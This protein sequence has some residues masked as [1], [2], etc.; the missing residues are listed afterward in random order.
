MALHRRAQGLS[1]RIPG[2]RANICRMSP[3]WAVVQQGKEVAD[4]AVVWLPG[5]G[6]E[7]FTESYVN[8]IP[9]MQGGTHVNGLRTGITE[10]VREFCEFRNL[11]PRGVKLAPEDICDRAAYVLSRED[12]RPAVFRPDQGTA[13]LAGIRQ[14]RVRR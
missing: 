13:V 2:R 5:D 1:D 8:L 7:M 10:A 3:S 12:E 14:L 9:T 4:W 6:G 11:V